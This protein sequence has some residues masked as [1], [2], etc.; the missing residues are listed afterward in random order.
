MNT[1]DEITIMQA[2]TI[3]KQHGHTVHRRT[4][5]RAYKSGQITGRQLPGGPKSPVLLNRRSVIAFAKK[6]GKS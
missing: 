2:L 4:V 3:L 6:R 5:L 1:Q